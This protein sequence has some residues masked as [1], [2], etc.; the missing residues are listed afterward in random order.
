MFKMT[1][2]GAG[3]QR[4]MTHYNDLAIIKKTYSRAVDT[5]SSFYGELIICDISDWMRGMGKR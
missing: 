2:G 4:M 5:K 1:K 3:N